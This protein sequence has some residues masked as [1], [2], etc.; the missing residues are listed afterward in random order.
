[1]QGSS[2]DGWPTSEPRMLELGKPTPPGQI[3]PRLTPGLVWSAVRR[4]EGR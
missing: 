2:E 3:L 1:L 4:V